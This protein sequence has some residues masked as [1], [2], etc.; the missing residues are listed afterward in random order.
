MRQ[1]SLANALG[2]PVQLLDPTEA[3]RLESLACD[4][5]VALPDEIRSHRIPES[6]R[7][8]VYEELRFSHEFRERMI[9][10]VQR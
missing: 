9:L 8:H 3:S 2:Y 10:S 6:D 5:L 7:M 4:F 1:R